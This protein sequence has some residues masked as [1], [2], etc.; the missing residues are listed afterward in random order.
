MTAA[1]LVAP[2]DTEQ[3]DLRPQLPTWQPIPMTRLPFPSL[4][5]GS[6]N[7]P[8]CQFARAQA[9]ARAW[10]SEWLDLGECGHI[11]ADSGLGDWPEGHALLQRLVAGATAPRPPSIPPI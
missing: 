3:P 8:Y 5:V 1:L 4:L 10:G 7:D 2:G 11:N 6:R 9:L